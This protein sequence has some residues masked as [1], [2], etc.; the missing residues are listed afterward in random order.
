MQEQVEDDGECRVL[1]IEDDEHQLSTLTELL[2]LEGFA[3]VTA[4]DGEAA[5]QRLL[6]G[7]VP[8]VIV[9]DLV[10]PGMDGWDFRAQQKRDPRFAAIPVVALSGVGRLIDAAHSLKKP[11]RAQELM[12]LL[13]ELC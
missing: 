11:L 8:D 5:W 9:L 12:G 2:T 1:V 6:A 7:P 13:A 4:T 3:V 10:L